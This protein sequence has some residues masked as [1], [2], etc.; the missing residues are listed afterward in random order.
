MLRLERLHFVDFALNLAS[1]RTYRVS[2]NFG[3]G[4]M[5]W[6]WLLWSV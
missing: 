2:Q 1:I 4:S 6:V 5:E 3:L